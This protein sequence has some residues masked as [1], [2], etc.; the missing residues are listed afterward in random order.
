MT[1][2]SKTYD[3]FD[4]IAI[5]FSFSDKLEQKRRPALILSSSLFNS[6]SNHFVTVMITSA[7]HSTWPLDTPIKNIKVAGLSTKCLIRMKFFTVDKSQILKKVGTLSKDDQKVFR[8][9]LKKIF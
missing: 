4:I 3:Q 2:L 6:S 8:M 7:K 9:N 1:K 5:P